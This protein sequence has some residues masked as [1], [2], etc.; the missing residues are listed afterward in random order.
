MKNV[1]ATRLV[2]V[3]AVVAFLLAFAMPAAAAPAAGHGIDLSWSWSPTSI[4]QWVQ[5]LWTGWFGAGSGA[6]SLSG[7]TNVHDALNSQTEPDGVSVAAN[8]SSGA[9]TTPT[10]D[11]GSIQ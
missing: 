6:G 7:M 10:L 9:Q 8:L 2:A 4:F 11:L 3:A 1:Y 5:S